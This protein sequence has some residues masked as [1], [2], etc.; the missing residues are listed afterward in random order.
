MQREIGDEVRLGSTVSPFD[1]IG[2]SSSIDRT[3]SNY[4]DAKNKK[5]IRELIA[6]EIMM[7]TLLDIFL[8]HSTWYSKECL[9]IS[10]RKK[11][12][13]IASTRTWDNLTFK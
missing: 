8:E 9:K 7:L 5:K 13:P 10:T 3:G 1:N 2:L 6:L 4:G 11:K 12:L